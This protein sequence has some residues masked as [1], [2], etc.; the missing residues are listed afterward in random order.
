[1]AAVHGMGTETFTFVK[2]SQ[3]KAGAAYR[4]AERQPSVQT[5]GRPAAMLSQRSPR[6]PAYAKCSGL[7]VACRSGADDT[8]SLSSGPPMSDPTHSYTLEEGAPHPLG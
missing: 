5:R 3:A 4:M 7:P 6:A 2:F 1:M 8:S